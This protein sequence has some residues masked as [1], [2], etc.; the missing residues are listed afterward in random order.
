[1]KAEIQKASD[2]KFKKDIEISTL[3]ELLSVID[4]YDSAIVLGYYT[5]DDGEKKLYITIYDDYLE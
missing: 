4:K 2:Y 1:M 5:E 3:E